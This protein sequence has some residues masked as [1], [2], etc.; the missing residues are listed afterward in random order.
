MAPAGLAVQDLSVTSLVFSKSPDGCYWGAILIR[1]TRVGLVTTLAPVGE[2]FVGVVPNST[3]QGVS[4]D[5]SS[6]QYHYHESERTWNSTPAQPSMSST[7]AL[8]PHHPPTA[9][10]FSHHCI[11]MAVSCTDT[12]YQTLAEEGVLKRHCNPQR[13]N[14]DTCV[15]S[16]GPAGGLKMVW[17][18]PT[19]GPWCLASFQLCCR[20][21]SKLFHLSACAL[22]CEMGKTVT[23][24]A[25]RGYEDGSPLH[26]L[27]HTR[28]PQWMWPVKV[29]QSCPTLCDPMDCSLPGSSVHGI[30]QARI[31]EWVAI[32]FSRRSSQPRDR[33]Q[34]SHI[35]GRFFT[36]WAT[37]ESLNVT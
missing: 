3:A 22:S 12:S 24:L 9:L 5:I 20:I 26:S 19:L 11:S 7:E 37:R 6:L 27:W 17:N 35:A 29:T 2:T 33:T 28:S 4:P 10:M 14:V 15:P 23:G 1:T 34:A 25:L 32:P 13:T 36:V 21:F 18:Q 16:R 30:L 8:S 31:M